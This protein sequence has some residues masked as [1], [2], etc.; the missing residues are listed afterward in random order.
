[1]A[2][3]RKLGAGGDQAIPFLKEQIRPIAVPPLDLKQV[4]K[5]LAELDSERF[6]TRER[7]TRELLRLGELAVVPLQR[8]LE[9]PSSVEAQRRAQNVLKKLAEPVLT[10][11]RLRAFEVLELLEQMRSLKAVA[12]LQEIE[13][14]ALIPQLRREARQ[15]SQRAAAARQEQK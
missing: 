2:G 1:E 11:D 10:P 4:E 15:A 6:V 8:L 13:R 5:L 9:K 14:D 3:W 12:L 7:A